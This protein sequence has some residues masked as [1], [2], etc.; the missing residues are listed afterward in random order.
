[1]DVIVSPTYEKTL[2]I[3]Y[4]RTNLQSLRNV[5][6]NGV[7]IKWQSRVKYL[8]NM[9]SYDL[10][11]DADVSAKECVFISAVN[12][13]VPSNIKVKLLQTYCTAWYGCQTWQL[14]TTAAGSMET[15]WKISVR[16]T[17]GLPPRTR[18][19]LL[20]GLAASLSFIHQHQRRVSQLLNTM[21]SST[22]SDVQYIAWRSVANTTGALGR[23]RAYLYIHRNLSG[24]PDLDG[25]DAE[26]NA[27]ITLIH[28]LLRVRD[29]LDRICEFT[30]S[31]AEEFLGHIS[32]FRYVMWVES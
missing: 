29:G 9:L 24:D 25:H 22:N 10:C 17:L 32:T 6:L 11:D 5:C 19:I 3:C 12:R 8:G 14:G 15:Q 2:F 21:M 31:D 7:P 1:M 30:K 18:S 28:E 20:P 26:V 23:N 16:K 4:G 27:R 13:G